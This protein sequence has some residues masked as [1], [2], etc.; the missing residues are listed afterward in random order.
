MNWKRTPL[1]TKNGRNYIELTRFYFLFKPQP[2]DLKAK[3][4]KDITARS[5]RFFLFL[6][7]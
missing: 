1:Q 4:V 6:R 7:L 2:S 5:G 3:A